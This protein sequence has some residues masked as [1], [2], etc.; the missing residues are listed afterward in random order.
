MTPLVGK[1][2]VAYACNVTV[3]IMCIN[4]RVSAGY[5]VELV[6][7]GNIGTCLSLTTRHLCKPI[8]HTI[9]GVV[10]TSIGTFCMIE[11][12]QSI[13]GIGSIVPGGIGCIDR[14]AI[15]IVI[16]GVCSFFVSAGI[17]NGEAA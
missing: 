16:I 7:V 13:I 9:I 1:D 12:V 17:G 14:S 3:G 10:H 5:L 4:Y 2:L 15:T 8:A 6:G 11:P